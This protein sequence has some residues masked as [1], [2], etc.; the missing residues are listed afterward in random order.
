MTPERWRH[1]EDLFAAA[2]EL[3]PACV[4]DWLRQECAGD[5]EL[6]REVNSLLR[7]HRPAAGP[8]AGLLGPDH[9][10][11]ERLSWDRLSW[12]R[13]FTDATESPALAA[14]TSFGP[15]I[16]R[17]FLGSGGMGDVYL[18]E[19]V[20]LNNRKV[21]LKLLPPWLD[22]E[23][24][25]VTR[26][27][28]EAYAASAL[29]HPNVPVVYEAGEIEGRHF[30]SS[31]YVDGAPL[32][33]RLA[34]GIVP[35]RE[36]IPLALQVARA[37]EAAHA[38]GIVHRDVKP[39]NILL[40]TDGRVKLV[41]F[42]VAKLAEGFERQVRE[43]VPRTTPGVVIGTPGYMAPEQ[44]AGTEVDARSDIWS[45]AA[46][47]HEMI[48]GRPPIPGSV[49][50]Q[51]GPNLPSSLA[52]V[53]ERALQPD[54]ARRYPAVTGFAD[55]LN[56]AQRGFGLFV[57]SPLGLAA[58][59]AAVLA[60]LA[61]G[62]LVLPLHRQKATESGFRIA[63]IVTLTTNGR[64]RNAAI[65]RDSRFVVY[66]TEESSGRQSLRLRE[67]DTEGDEERIPARSGTYLGLTFDPDGKYFYYTFGVRDSLKSLF[68]ASV[69][70]GSPD[71]KI[72]D[73]IDSPASVSPEGQRL[74]YIRGN[75]ERQSSEV[76]IADI[77][78]SHDRVLTA[79]PLPRYFSDSGVA[80]SNDGKQIF[81]GE[82]DEHLKVFLGSIDVSNG[83]RRVLSP[84][85]WSW[86]G[87]ISLLSDRETLIFPV[88]PTESTAQEL[89]RFSTTMLSAQAVAPDL[90]DFIQVYSAGTDIVAVRRSSLSSVWIAPAGNLGS[91]APITDSAGH[92]SQIAW[93][94]DGTLVSSVREAGHVNLTRLW[95]DGARQQLTS[96]AFDDS[97][98]AVSP[99]GRVIAFTS[100]RANG[101]SI[102][103]TDPGGSGLRPLTKNHVQDQLPSFLP[104]GSVLFGRQS[105][106]DGRF[107]IWKM[108]PQ[109]ETPVRL[110]TMSAMNPIAS[111]SGRY[112]ACLIQDQASSGWQ[113]AVVDLSSLAVLGR[114]PQIPSGT[115]VRWSPDE[116]AL[117][118]VRDIGGV[119]NI[120]KTSIANRLE[121]AVTH[122]REDTIFS[123]D[124]SPK[125]HDLAM[126]RGIPA[127]DV[128]LLRRAR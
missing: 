52:R 89:V 56:H 42:G 17:G 120:W 110:L 25:L 72:I 5:D 27:T 117:T 49:R 73:D 33:R 35:R 102:W 8:A 32:T 93:S 76:H 58:A 23:E 67:V 15:Y 122:F 21:A 11:W 111:P 79:N 99:D 9:L 118:Y 2:K 75:A 51:V 7:Y 96:G 114:F 3:S 77:D 80:W 126:V 37:L 16:I 47:L 43:L 109:G 48:S 98:P 70:R 10:S 127:S 20:R 62:Y 39:G 128:I 34:Q 26:F 124:W 65:S 123:F 45:L 116:K 97:Q 125:S 81:A 121:E 38:A 36:A 82:F 113:V 31:E 63:Q 57:R 50:V 91:A 55:E 46:V 71:R 40:S 54:P 29:N 22:R 24:R 100:N 78:G 112:L 64:V 119:S 66:S 6:E 105:D 108:K 94:P 19:D 68:R 13:A 88:T 41:D 83:K 90:K 14:G 44:A 95:R 84:P 85:N 12:E 61:F 60:I 86:M 53:L 107:G 115:Q 69:L 87:R 30:I 4:D 104:D 1:V 101:W 103:V 92:F 106:I 74:A 18:A 28:H 59:S